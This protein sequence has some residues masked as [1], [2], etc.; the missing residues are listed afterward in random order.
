MNKFGS[1]KGAGWHN[2]T[3]VY[4]AIFS[5]IEVKSLFEMGIGT[6]DTSIHYNMGAA[7]RPG[8]SLFGWES[9]FPGAT[10]VSADIDSS[11]L[12]KTDRIISF[13]CDQ[14]SPESIARLWEQ[15]EIPNSFDV[16]IDDGLHEFGANCTLFEHSVHKLRAGGVYVVEDI[17]S[18]ELGD[19]RHKIEKEYVNRFPD[20][21]FRLTML[22]N[23]T[24]ICDNNILIVYC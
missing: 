11:I 18:L 16:M 15:P 9:Y 7:G 8:A 19:W 21:V 2:Y 22:P 10:I 23:P 5:S 14:T 12:F 4:D 20:F 24:N 3:K 1:D 6:T 17:K 13:Q